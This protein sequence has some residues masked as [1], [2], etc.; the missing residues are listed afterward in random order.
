MGRRFGHNGDVRDF[1]LRIRAQVA[2]CRA[3]HVHACTTQ[4]VHKCVC[5]AWHALA[6][7]MCVYDACVCIY[8]VHLDL[9]H[10]VQCAF[11]HTHLWH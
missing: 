5:V 6:H 9:I 3:S 7:L 8:G 10:A 2:L 11:A 4:S 1:P